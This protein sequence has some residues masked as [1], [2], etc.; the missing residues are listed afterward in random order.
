MMHG[1]STGSPV[2]GTPRTHEKFRSPGAVRLALQ[3]P[4]RAVDR[5]RGDGGPALLHRARRRLSPAAHPL[6]Q[7]EPADAGWRRRSIRL[8]DDI[9]D[10]RGPPGRSR[11]RAGRSRRAAAAAVELL[12]ER[13]QELD[14]RVH[15][16]KERRCTTRSSGASDAEPDGTS[17][18]RRPEPSSHGSKSLRRDH[19]VAEARQKELLDCSTAAAQGTIA[20]ALDRR[21]DRHRAK[22]SR[23]TNAG[24]IAA[25]WPSR[26]STSICPSES[27]TT[28]AAPDRRW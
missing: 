15:E 26:T 10:A 24:S 14:R 27:F 9:R 2:R 16:A 18:S 6:R 21:I 5:L 11:A 3:G 22:R 8:D 28:L 4:V 25:R 19:R 7:P 12:K 1:S 20:Y 17:R 13:F 23:A